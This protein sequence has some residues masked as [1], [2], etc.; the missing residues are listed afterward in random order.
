MSA[1]AEHL[2]E[3]IFFKSLTSKK[4]IKCPSIHAWALLLSLSGRGCLPSQVFPCIRE[5]KI[6]QRDGNENVA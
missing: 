5:F 6:Q 2:K 4:I 1:L 3:K